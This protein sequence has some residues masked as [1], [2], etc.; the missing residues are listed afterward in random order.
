MRTRRHDQLRRALVIK[1][2]Y[3][4]QIVYC[5]FS[6]IIART[7]A[8]PGKLAGQRLSERDQRGARDAWQSFKQL[9]D[10][11]PDSRYADDARVRM[12]FIVNSLA[13]YEV[14]VARY[15]LRRGAYVA[16]ANRAQQA[17]AE[18]SQS[19]SVEEALAIMVQS[20]DKLGL[21]SLRDDA[22]RVLRKNFPHSTYLAGAA[23]AND[24]P[25]WKF[26]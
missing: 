11:F 7:D 2:L 8:A 20:Y 5:L 13:E 4:L 19:P 12:D 14:N 10:Q 1:P 25:W 9:V 16:A 18:Y 17:L 3:T 15:Y 26:W 24:K 21:V 6:Q 22:E 23:P